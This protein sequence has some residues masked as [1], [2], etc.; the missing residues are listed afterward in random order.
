MW[1]MLAGVGP[2][3]GEGIACYFI[4]AD[5]IETPWGYQNGASLANGNPITQL[6]DFHTLST[7]NSKVAVLLDNG[8]ASSGEVITI[9]L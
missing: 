5:E 8:I 7:E 1:P 9:S 6:D 2:L 3:L 4:D